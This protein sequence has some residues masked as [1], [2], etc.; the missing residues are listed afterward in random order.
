[1]FGLARLGPHRAPADRRPRRASASSPSTIGMTQRELSF[2][3]EAKGDPCASQVRRAALDQAS[4][5]QYLAVGY[6]SAPNSHVQRHSQ[7][8]PPGTALIVADER[9]HHRSD[10]GHWRRG[11]RSRP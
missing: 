6:V 7:K 2:A 3:S 5:A 10:S 9:L 1:M 11:R 8:L 4:L